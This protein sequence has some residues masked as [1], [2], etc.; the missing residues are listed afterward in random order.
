M[1]KMTEDEISFFPED[2]VPFKVTYGQW[3]VKWWHW[4]LS[5]PKSIS[6]I[7]DQSGEYASV[8]QPTED[9]WFLAGKFGNEDRNL[10]NRF[11]KIPAGRSILFP[12][13]N[14]EAN[15]LEYPELRTDEDL[16]EHIRR[17]EDTIINRDCFV[18]SKRIPVY[19][20]QS[21]PLI[22]EVRIDED[23]A[24]N[25]VGGGTT[26]AS[27]DGYWVFLKP[28]QLGEHIISFH[29]SCENGRLNSGANYRVKVE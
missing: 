12:V 17:D 13:I 24:V 23:N 2:S 27:A 20:V 4:A 18:D 10:P 7:V 15:P 29:G 1:E 6:P 19:R 3:T 22:F 21:D 8:N 9:V 5:T 11:C 14:C 16:I 25:V 26:M 28:L